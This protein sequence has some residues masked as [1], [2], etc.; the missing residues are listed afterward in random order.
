[1]K[2]FELQ[3]TFKNVGQ[4]DC[5]FIEWF[6]S[7]GDQEIGIIDC[8]FSSN[9]DFE[10]IT[11]HISRYRTISFLV[12][13]HPHTDHFSGLKRILDHC[14]EHDI[15]IRQIM[16]T[17]L[18]HESN[19]EVQIV[20]KVFESF[21]QEDYTHNSPRKELFE[22]FDRFVLLAKDKERPTAIIPI[23]NS[24]ALDLDAPGVTFKFLSP[25]YSFEYPEYLSTLELAKE[26]NPALNP[27][28][29]PNAN[30]LS[31]VL[32]IKSVNWHLLLTSDARKKSLKRV[33]QRYPEVFNSDLGPL[34]LAQV[35][36]HGSGNLQETH[37]PDFWDSL[38]DVQLSSAFISSG[39][40]IHA[41]PRREV[42]EFYDQQTIAV[43]ATNN[44]YGYQ[45]FYSKSKAKREVDIMSALGWIAGEQKKLGRD[46]YECGEQQIKI[47]ADGTYS[48]K[49]S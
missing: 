5:I 27:S 30:I 2:D 24:G 17:A 33:Q 15:Y 7:K 26:I 31:S 14:V 12:L 8:N 44:V 10:A 46:K 34:I 9:H 19:L 1:M 47:Q 23:T 38:L 48:L 20:R 41:H 36:H 4:G 16:H 3:L 45:E 6:N 18:Y 21:V 43:H 25:D 29:N 37:Y 42:V 49:T 11:E 39:R 28:N 40:S 22:L 13:S 32:Y 35:P